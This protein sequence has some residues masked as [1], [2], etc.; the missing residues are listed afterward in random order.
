MQSFATHPLIYLSSYSSTSLY[1]LSIII[2]ISYYLPSYCYLSQS[3]RTL[4]HLQTL[5]VL[6]LVRWADKGTREDRGMKEV[7]TMRTRICCGQGT[8]SP[9]TS[10]PPIDPPLIKPLLIKPPPIKQSQSHIQGGKA[11]LPR[12]GGKNRRTP[13]LLLSSPVRRP[14]H[15]GVRPRHLEEGTCREGSREP[16]REGNTTQHTTP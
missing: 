16:A 7:T 4:P 5:L 14:R 12:S 13:H 15:P 11:P 6:V 10:T 9:V 1:P 3:R 2:P 8:A